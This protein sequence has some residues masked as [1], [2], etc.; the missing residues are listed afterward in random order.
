M[1][2]LQAFRSKA[3][4]EYNDVIV[5]SF[6]E[7]H[8]EDFTVRDEYNTKDR[9]HR[10]MKLSVDEA[11]SF[12]S[13]F[14]FKNWPDAQR[15]ANTIRYLRYLSSEETPNPLQYVYF[16][17]MAYDSAPR[18]RSF[19]PI[20]K[21]LAKNTDL[22]AGPS[23]VHDSTNYPGDRHI[24]GGEETLTIQLHHIEF[25]GASLDYPRTAYTLAIYYPDSLATNYYANEQNADD[26]E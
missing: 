1:T 25:D 14:S 13:D 7:K 10:W 23:S 19:D 16:Y 21:K 15:K 26:D 17:Q 24:T 18:H 22:F 5:K 20:E 9:T 4:I 12:L 3:T 8:K 11:I 6:L 2:A